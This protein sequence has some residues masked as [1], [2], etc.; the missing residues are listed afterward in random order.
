DA[1]T[2]RAADDSSRSLSSVVLRQGTAQSV[3]GYRE[4]GLADHPVHR[5]LD[6]REPLVDPLTHIRVREH[7]EFAV[8]D[9]LEHARSDG[10]G[11]EPGLQP[12]G[13]LRHHRG[14]RARRIQ[15]LHRAVALRPVPAAVGN[16][17]AHI[18]RTQHADPN[19]E[20][21]ELGG[22]A[23][24][25]AD[26]RELARRVRGK[27]HAVD[28]PGHRGGVD[29]VAA[30]AMAAN[31]RQEG[32]D[33]V[34]HAHQV[35]VEHPAPIVERDAV[36]A[37]AGGDPGIVADHMDL[38]EGLKGGVRGALDACGIGDVADDAAYVR[39]EIVQALDGGRQ[40]IGFD[41]REHHLHAALRK[42]PAEREPDA[43]GAA[44]HECRLAGDL[45]HDPL[46]YLRIMTDAR[47]PYL[48][49]CTRT[50][51]DFR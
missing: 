19:S 39:R 25:Y 44:G 46:R 13:D 35:D 38:A 47:H 11:L 17:G 48:H 33:A 9:G 31:M 12:P 32:P 50:D 26:H 8:P 7:V 29:D 27:T 3:P 4:F 43:A 37:A 49:D 24:R 23:F 22:E 21:R 20:R 10:V 16:A 18:F 6:A 1:A 36:E 5:R 15:G 40:R 2:D 45:P 41:I 30:F 34:N 42:G 28:H 14:R 51:S